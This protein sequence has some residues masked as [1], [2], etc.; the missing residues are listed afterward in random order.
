MGYYPA[1]YL[2]YRYQGRESCFKSC[3]EE[4]FA[5]LVV[6][7]CEY[8]GLVFSGVVCCICGVFFAFFVFPGHFCY[9]FRPLFVCFYANCSFFDEFFVFFQQIQGSSNK[10]PACK[11]SFLGGFYACL[12]CFVFL[13]FSFFLVFWEY[14]LD[15]LAFF[16]VFHGVEA[17]VM[18]AIVVIVAVIL[19]IVVIMEGFEARRRL[20]KPI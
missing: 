18:I 14:F 12:C 6:F 11:S 1:F 17:V 13:Y 15:F 4:C 19:I 7:V 10:F 16:R 20:R 2:I 9:H 8:V 3:V 5:G